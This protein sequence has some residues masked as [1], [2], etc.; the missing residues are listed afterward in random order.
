MLRLI[1]GSVTLAAAGY[2]LKEFCEMEGCPWDEQRASSSSTDTT[3]K[4]QTTY[5]YAKKFHKKKKTAYKNGMQAYA[6]FLEQYKVEDKEIQTDLKLR[7]QK[8]PDESVNEEVKT[9]LEKIT[10]MTEVLSYN[11]QL[12]C[13]LLK[14]QTE[15]KKEDKELMQQYAHSLYALA[16]LNIFTLYD[17]F[18]KSE[19]LEVM[20]DAMSLCVGKDS[21]YVDLGE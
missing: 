1:I 16:H 10:H 12:H 5:T 6:M 7:K 13:Q 9:A 8:F 4:K 15:L 17:T 11:I 21:F 2:A 3:T 20:Y 19:F 18:N 14:Q